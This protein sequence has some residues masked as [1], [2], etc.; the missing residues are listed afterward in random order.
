VQLTASNAGG[1]PDS[2]RLPISV[3]PKPNFNIVANPDSGCANLRVVFPYISGASSYNWTFGDGGTGTTGNTTHT[4]VNTTSTTVTYTTQAIV[5]DV[6]GCKDTAT[7]TIKVFPKPVANFSA[8]PTSVI[9]S[10]QQVNITNL[11]S[12]YV[13]SN[14]SFGD[15]ATSTDANPTHVYSLGGDWTIRLIVI[16][17]KGCKDTFELGVTAVDENVIKVPNAFTPNLNASNG[18]SYV[19]TELNNDVFHPIIRGVD[20][21]KYELSIYSRWGE[22]LFVSKDIDIGWDGYYKGQLCTQD[23][24][25][26]KIKAVTKEGVVID[27]AGDVTLLR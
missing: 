16:S 12:G 13:T 11:S 8:D 1:C 26:W 15:G 17:N 2:A 27:K 19:P 7:R 14:W 20:R 21:S 24:Y 4:F 25:I 23:V 18:G 10:N 3:H 6:F 9:T 22:L 5:G